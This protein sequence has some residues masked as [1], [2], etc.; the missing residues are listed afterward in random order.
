MQKI[1]I[2]QHHNI[3]FNLATEEFF[4]KHTT[5]NIIMLWR[6]SPCI[7]VGKHQNLFAE[8]NLP[9]LLKN[10]I[11]LA[12][13]LS[14][15]GTVY[16]DLGN[17]NFTFITTG[18]EGKLIDFEKQTN[19]IIEAINQL[20][21]NAS[22]GPRNNIFIG[23]QK[24]SGNAEHIY[25]KRILH[26]GTLLFN[27]NLEILED[28]I[29]T[30]GDKFKDKAVKSVR[31]AVTNISHHLGNEM[32]IEEFIEHLKSNLSKSNNHIKDITLSQ[33]EMHMI[34]SLKKEK[35]ETEKWIYNYSPNYTFS[36]EIVIENRTY[37]LQLI[38][39]KG[40][41]EQIECSH[42]GMQSLK[43]LDH[44][45]QILKTKLTGLFPKLNDDELNDLCIQLFY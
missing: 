25:R 21:V 35:Y 6:S 34:D 14:G 22:L 40:I 31:A 26:H 4:L 3:F 20:G 13:R 28:T 19:P 8:V 16:H 23:N 1:Y 12:R 24:I 39:K 5:D 7:V 38:V 36:G 44:Q 45:L 29:R 27:S 41:I 17:I 42:I 9:Y 32:S 33:D 30:S 11:L 2:S 18:E 37:P 43:G 15:G 10:N